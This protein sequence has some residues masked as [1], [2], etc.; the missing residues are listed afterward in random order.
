MT[1]HVSAPISLLDVE[2]GADPIAAVAAAPHDR[3][4]VTVLRQGVPQAIVECHAG[5]R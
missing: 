3:L 5:R 2:L 4:W 1:V